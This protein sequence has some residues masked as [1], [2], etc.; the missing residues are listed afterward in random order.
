MKK[1]TSLIKRLG[2]WLVIGLR[3]VLGLVVMK[4]GYDLAAGN[5]HYGETFGNDPIT[6]LFIIIV[7][8]YF[9]F[10]SLLRHLLDN[11]A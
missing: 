5:L 6:P 11:N 10:S 2:T 9:T 3:T 4:T 8:A 1:N 7:G